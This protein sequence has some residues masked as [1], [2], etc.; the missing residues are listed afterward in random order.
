MTDLEARFMRP[1]RLP[2]KD[3]VR[4]RSLGGGSAARHNC[5]LLGPHACCA[6]RAGAASDAGLMRQ[7]GPALA[8]TLCTRPPPHFLLP[9]NLALPG[10]R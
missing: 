3:E 4:R 10:C 7:H 8:P 1:A 6:V 9:R 5:Q 2:C